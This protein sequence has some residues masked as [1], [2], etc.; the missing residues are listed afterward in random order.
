MEKTPEVNTIEWFREWVGELETALGLAYAEAEALSTERDE[1]RQ[2]HVATFGVV[3]RAIAERDE[4]RAEVARL[5]DRVQAFAEAAWNLTRLPLAAYPELKGLQGIINELAAAMTDQEILG[6][7]SRP[8]AAVS[9]DPARFMPRP[10][11]D[12]TISDHAP[13]E[14]LI[15]LL[16]EVARLRDV[17]GN[18]LAGIEARLIDDEMPVEKLPLYGPSAAWFYDAIRAAQRELS[19]PFTDDTTV[20]KHAPDVDHTF[21]LGGLMPLP[22]SV[23]RIVNDTEHTQTEND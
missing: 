5:R 2:T 15:K 9:G 21:D 18:L 23:E 4:L 12:D 13:V 19:I 8:D 11:A 22:L 10:F 1:L 16:A 14:D 17:L 20:S 6:D 3:E 7:F